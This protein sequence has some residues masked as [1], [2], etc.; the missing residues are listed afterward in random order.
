[1]NILIIN[2][3]KDQRI[4][5]RNKKKFIYGLQGNRII[6]KKWNDVQG[7]NNTLIANKISGIIISGSDYF[8]NEK[9]HSII[10][11]CILKSKIPIL[12]IC[13]GFQYIVNKYGKS[14]Y[15][16]SFANGYRKY[17]CNFQIKRPFY[18]PKSKYY[19]KHTNYIVNVPKN[20]KVIKRNGDKIIVA[21]NSKR[22]IFAVQFH[23]EIYKKSGRAFFKMWID[24]C[25]LYL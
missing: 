15:I 18:I 14:S 19:F 11:D 21:Y 12:A 22:N 10:D 6:F 16:K 4:Y 7:I 20:F 1:M 23:P 17:S 5:K 13:Y 25:V 3:F 24:K 9:G 2:M 8:V